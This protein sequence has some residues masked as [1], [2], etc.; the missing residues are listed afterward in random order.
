M[1]KLMPQE[2][3]KIIRKNVVLLFPEKFLEHDYP[4][5]QRRN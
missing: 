1:I 2:L 3:L 4:K 5:N